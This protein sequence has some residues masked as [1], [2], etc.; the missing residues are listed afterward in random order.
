M[1]TIKIFTAGV[2]AAIAKDAAKQFEKEHAGMIC[3]LSAGGSNAGINRLRAGEIFDV[4][5]LADNDNIEQ[6]L[7]PE[8]ADGYYIWGGNAMVVAGNGI[9][10]EN[11]KEKLLAPQSRILHTDPYHD[12]SGYR[13]VMAM[14][15]ADT[16]E[17]GLA[18]KLLNHPN[19]SG[20][21]PQHYVG[22]FR[23]ISALKDDEYSILYR[24]S[25][26]SANLEHAEL[27]PEMN[28]SDPSFDDLYHTATFQIASGETVHGNMI[29]HAILIPKNA[30]HRAE[31]EAY[32]KLFLERRFMA[33]G[34]TP[35]Q[36]PVGNWTVEL[37]D[38][39]AAEHQFYNHMTQ[40][41]VTGTNRQLDCIPL[42]PDF[43]V[44]DCGCGTG[45]LAI[46][47]AKRVKKVICLD[48]SRSMLELCKQNCAAA[49]VTN[50]EFILAD[51]QRA[52]IG[53]NVPEVDAVI[54]ARGGGGPSTLSLLR[55]AARRYAVTISLAEGSPKMPTTRTLLFRGC[56]SEEAMRRYPELR[57]IANGPAG[58]GDAKPDF[59]R[60]FSMDMKGKV[61]MGGP[62]MISYLEERGIA[63]HVAT[64]EDGWD[65]QFKTRQEAYDWF[66]LLA[67]YPELL[68]MERFRKNADALLTKNEEG[69]DFF[70]PTRTEIIW[71]KTR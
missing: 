25:A 63:A 22:G 54:Q 50:V 18:E 60:R 17:P 14:Q 16:I 66:L 32:A 37:P 20:L 24:S 33:H 3:E 19:Y 64:I 6:M 40:M 15:L 48:V 71:F 57:R 34:F 47:A 28:Q 51:W 68:D 4:M 26:I 2:A 55:Q 41:E 44:L 23:P 10:S 61:P 39:W 67:K 30:E 11:W 21:D 70:L 65:R 8:Y 5:I 35:V 49:N 42:E 29:L 52:K 56:Y 1:K 69:Y 38:I 31:A 27:P 59:G 9:T 62:R 36:S 46:E 43:V 53:V 58:K 12:P 45:R 7:M 13:A